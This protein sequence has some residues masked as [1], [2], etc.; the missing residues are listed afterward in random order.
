[1]D[2]HPPPH[3]GTLKTV[4]SARQAEIAQGLCT[5]KSDALVT[6]TVVIG[7]TTIATN[8][9]LT[10]IAPIHDALLLRVDGDLQYVA[11]TPN[12]LTI[13]FH[14]ANGHNLFQPFDFDLVS[15]PEAS[16]PIATLPLSVRFP[17]KL[18]H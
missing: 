18:N 1:M 2:T 16:V 11:S 5:L 17:L 13:T 6:I 8:V 3:F 4:G 9:A 7:S 12:Q 10:G 14:K 15:A